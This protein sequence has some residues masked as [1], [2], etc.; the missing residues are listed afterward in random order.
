MSE[1][2][3]AHRV[4]LV[5][6]AARGLGRAIAVRLARDGHTV[7]VA[8]L[9]PSDTAQA[10]DAVTADGGRAFPIT[11]DVRDDRQIAQAI[12]E[13][14]ARFT[15]LDVLVNNAGVSGERAPIDAF[16]LA[17][18]DDVMRTNLTSMFLTC[19]R[20][21]PLM[22]RWRWGRIVNLSSLSA[23]G[24]PGTNRVGYVASKAG[25]IGFSRALAEEVGADGITVN[26]VAPS[27][28]RTDLT[29]TIAAGHDEYWKR[30]AAG[31]VL[32]RLGTPE[33]IA[34][35]VAWLCSDRAS[36]VTGAVLDVNGGTIMR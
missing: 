30:G 36:F 33:D 26:C 17:G 13:I 35:A 23:R 12:A 8:D 31:S 6:G 19:R 10:A 20:A 32:G 9:D 11:L 34:G 29:A 4:A 5:T 16:S 24:Q 2:S 18:W 21:M 15:R 7:F 28:I 14:E 1:R 27:R 25:I 3:E 22:R